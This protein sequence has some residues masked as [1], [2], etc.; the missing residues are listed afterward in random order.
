MVRA[1]KNFFF[2]RIS[3]VIAHREKVNLLSIALENLHLSSFLSLRPSLLQEWPSSFVLIFLTAIPT[4]RPPSSSPH[5]ATTPTWT[6]WETVAQILHKKVCGRLAHATICRMVSRSFRGHKMLS[7]KSYFLTANC[8]FR[9]FKSP[10]TGPVG[11]FYLG[12]FSTSAFPTP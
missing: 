1:E 8:Y 6:R 12:W 2:T 9:F 4:L 10:Q 7:S 11:L 5:P 3:A